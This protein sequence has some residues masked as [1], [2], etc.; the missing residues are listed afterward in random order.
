MHRGLEARCRGAQVP[1]CSDELPSVLTSLCRQ[2]TRRSGLTLSQPLGSP[3]PF[4][5]PHVLLFLN[6]LPTSLCLSGP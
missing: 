1:G 4:S 3:N 6:V 2:S 5:P